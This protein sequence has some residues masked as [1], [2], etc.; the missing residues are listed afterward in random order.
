M[1]VQSPF[2]GN[3]SGS[4]T[5]SIFQ[6]YRGRTYKRTKPFIYHYP[7]TPAQ[8][9]NQAKFYN[10]QTPLRQIYSLIKPY[11]SNDQ[12]NGFSPFNNFSKGLYR[13]AQTFPPFDA[14]EQ[15]RHFGLDIYNRI[16]IALGDHQDYFLD[17]TYYFTFENF[18]IHAV[19]DFNP[20]QAYA[21]YI[22]TELQQIQFTLI[23]FD[24]QRLAFPYKNTL[25]WF[26]DHSF[27]MWVALS[28]EN[29]FSDFYY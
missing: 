9:A 10:I 21:I 8:R 16:H 25:N 11:Y 7:G 12:S 17:D 22:C 14:P 23:S 18:S 27:D 20:T 5:G 4:S 15:I 2:M 24:A 3:M 29:F 19:V 1:R 26:P 28:D 6:C 13:A